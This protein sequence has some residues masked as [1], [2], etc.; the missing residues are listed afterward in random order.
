MLTRARFSP[1]GR[2]I[3][4]SLVGEGRPAHG[5]VYVMTADGRNEEAVAPHPAEDQLLDWTP[6]GKGLL[7]R[8][9]RSGT[10]D[11]WSVRVA[12]GKSQGEPE[13]LKKDFGRYTQLLGAA[14]DG[15]IYYRTITPSG[16]L[17][18]GELDIESGKVSRRP[19]QPHGYNGAP[20]GS[21]GRLTAGDC[22]TCRSGAPWAT[23]TTIS[24][25][26]LPTPGKSGSCRPASATC[27]ISAG[28]RTVDRSSPGG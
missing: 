7:F 20:G 24:P 6:D 14:P 25:S 18:L 5:N 27:G 21:R 16:R 2:F 22:S 19:R 8:S 13:L 28:H 11:I 1:D 17:Y 12:D 4:F 10:W 23:A 26:G 3:A 15:A 9:D